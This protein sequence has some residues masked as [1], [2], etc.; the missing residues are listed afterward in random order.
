MLQLNIKLTLRTILQTSDSHSTYSATSR[1]TS[2]GDVN[3]SF[4]RMQT[5]CKQMLKT[6]TFLG[7]YQENRLVQS[8]HAYRSLVVISKTDESLA[9]DIQIVRHRIKTFYSH[10]PDFWMGFTDSSMIGVPNGSCLWTELDGIP[11]GEYWFQIKT[12]RFRNNEAIIKL[13]ILK[14]MEDVVESIRQE[15]K[16]KEEQSTYD[17]GQMAKDVQ[18]LL[19]M[20]R[21]STSEYFLW[22]FSQQ[23]TAKNIA[24]VLKFICLMVLAVGSGC[25]HGLMYLGAFTLKFMAEFR[26]LLHVSMPIILKALDLLSKVIGGIFLL[27]AMIYR[28]LFGRRGPP[29]Y[30]QGPPI[31]SLG[32]SDE[33]PLRAIQ[34]RPDLRNNRSY[35]TSIRY[36]RS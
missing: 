6:R 23:I 21:K 36:R 20:W 29:A 27:V 31:P 30:S 9:K 14:P 8:L 28:D 33:P 17:S 4:D 24:S 13:K 5:F 25:I 1:D 34:H 11:F 35:T 32:F 16:I 22:L 15:H 3:P 19:E 18:E 26:K 12:I 10:N 7:H 2:A